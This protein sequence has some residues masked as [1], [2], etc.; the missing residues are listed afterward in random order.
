VSAAPV[1][2]LLGLV[3][4]LGFLWYGS[5]QRRQEAILQAHEGLRQ[6]E[7]ANT[8]YQSMHQGLAPLREEPGLIIVHIAPA[9][10]APWEV[11]L[12]KDDLAKT[13]QE[14]LAKNNVDASRYTFRIIPQVS[15]ERSIVARRVE[16]TIHPPPTVT[17]RFGD[18][19]TLHFSGTG[20]MEWM[21]Q[22]RQEALA[23]PGIQA[24]DMREVNDPRKERLSA[25]VQDIESTVVRFSLGRETPIP[26]DAPMLA[27]AV[28]TL[29]ELEKLAAEMGIAVSLT[30]FGHADAVGNERRN[31]EISQERAR[32]LAAMLYARGSSLP[33]TMYGMGAEYTKDGAT[34]AD[35]NSRRIELKVHLSRAG[36]A[37]PDILRQ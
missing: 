21:L 19:G 33:I 3:G 30:I 12:L 29:A 35:E 5:Y 23:L 7:D 8:F 31:Y 32:T 6:T 14:V 10:T 20:P 2:L 25:M 24:I 37:A 36:D 28:N 17:M 4:G 11:L 9:E 26:A 18:D 1:L 27:A 13:P 22:A 15:Y 16:A 34:A